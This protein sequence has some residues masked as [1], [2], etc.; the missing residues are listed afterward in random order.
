M[1]ET[2][3]NN[4]GLYIKYGRKMDTQ[5]RAGEYELDGPNH[6]TEVVLNLAQLTAAAQIID[7][8]VSIPA[9]ARIARVE[10]VTDTVA[11]GVGAVLNVGIIDQDRSTVIDADGFV[12]ALP[13]ASMDAAGET[14]VLYVG[15]SYAGSSI[16]VTNNNAG[17]ITADYDTAAFTQGKV[18]VRIFWY[19]P[20]TATAL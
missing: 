6:V 2:W 4:D 18:V 19:V 12:A 15:T 3:L 16:G 7:D 8:T 20:V 5:A 11:A 1:A 9:N 17:L 13:T 14:T 10:V